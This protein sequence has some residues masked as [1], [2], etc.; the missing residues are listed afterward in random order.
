MWTANQESHSQHSSHELLGPCLA[1]DLPETGRR[2]SKAEASG[3]PS[4]ALCQDRK[5]FQV[6]TRVPS[7]FLASLSAKEWP[8]E[9]LGPASR[10]MTD[11]SYIAL[12]NPSIL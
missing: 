7:P 2:Q 4:T 8:R 9:F 3:S 11:H 12:P 5:S 10:M 6:N 1:R